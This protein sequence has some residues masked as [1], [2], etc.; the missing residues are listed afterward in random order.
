VDGADGS[1]SVAWPDDDTNAAAR[2]ARRDR[3]YGD[4]VR[5]ERREGSSHEAA[6]GRDAVAHEADDRDAALD[7]DA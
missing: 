4:A 3:V 7:R 2:A 5:V 6:P 1:P